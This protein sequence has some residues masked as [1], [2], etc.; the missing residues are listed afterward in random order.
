[1]ACIDRFQQNIKYIFNLR[2]RFYI[3]K[4]W[5]SSL[6]ITMTCR[7]RS[8]CCTLKTSFGRSN[9]TIK[10]WNTEWVKLKIKLNQESSR[11]KS[12]TAVL[13]QPE[14][15]LSKKSLINWPKDMCALMPKRNKFLRN[16]KKSSL[17][18]WLE[19]ILRNPKHLVDNTT[20]KEAKASNFKSMVKE[21][22]F[23]KSQQ[24]KN[25][26]MK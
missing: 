16:R 7:N 20:K 26:V 15:R 23:R 22:K 6:T 11:F 4:Q 5:S 2:Q 3:N 9:W 18:L 8:I 1:M 25:K 19:V 24:I 17:D 13:L 14:L 12:N 21:S 10:M